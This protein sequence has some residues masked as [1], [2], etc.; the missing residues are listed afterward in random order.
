MGDAQPTSQRTSG[1]QRR[2]STKK[3]Q[4]PPALSLTPESCQGI[5]QKLLEATQAE[6][7]ALRNALPAPQL[8][9][10]L[11]QAA[12]LLQQEPTL[13]EVLPKHPY[14]VQA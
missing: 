8:K 10:L 4:T 12:S 14:D 2:P 3:S 9:Q 1:R 5:C 7:A 13:L 6:P 11:D